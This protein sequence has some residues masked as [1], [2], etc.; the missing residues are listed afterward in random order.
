MDAELGQ[1]TSL[2]GQRITLNPIRRDRIAHE[3]ARLDPLV[4]DR[5][6]IPECGELACARK[7]RG[8]GA[9]HGDSEPVVRLAPPERRAGR[10]RDV[11]RKAL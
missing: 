8:T 11:T 4:V 2:R 10:E 7:P 9:N 6:V 5:D 3:A 1:H